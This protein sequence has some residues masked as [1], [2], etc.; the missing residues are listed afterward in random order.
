MFLVTN[1]NMGLCLCIA[2]LLHLDD[3][4]NA[5]Q[6]NRGLVILDWYFGVGMETHKAGEMVKKERNVELVFK[7]CLYTQ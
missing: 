1:E 5:I 6:K 3:V 7:N 4:T 2:F